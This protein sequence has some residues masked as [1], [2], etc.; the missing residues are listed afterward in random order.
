MKFPK[1]EECYQGDITSIE[2]CIERS[3]A[4][5]KVWVTM[6]KNQYE[7]F[8]VCL[9]DTKE[10]DNPKYRAIHSYG[11]GQK[12]VKAQQKEAREYY[13]SA[14]KKLGVLPYPSADNG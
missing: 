1:I 7:H 2:I 9:I 8:Q 4:K 6:W 14:C 11:P 13:E 3:T 12:E 10:K 5:E